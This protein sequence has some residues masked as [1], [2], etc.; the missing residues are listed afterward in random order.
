MWCIVNAAFY[1]EAHVIEFN[2]YFPLFIFTYL[3]KIH[4]VVPDNETYRNMQ[5][6]VILNINIYRIKLSLL[7]LSSKVVWIAGWVCTNTNVPL[8][9]K[10]YTSK[11]IDCLI[12]RRLGVVC[13]LSF[14]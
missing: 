13:F 11:A 4:T 8:S 3:S 10:S 2:L 7:V 12:G 6:Q 5:N 14:Q 1:T 9:I